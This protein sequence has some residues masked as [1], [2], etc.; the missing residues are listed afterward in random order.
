MG[1]PAAKLSVSVPSK[2]A[3]ELRR[4]VGARGLSGFVTRAIAHELERQRLGVLLAE[5]DAELGAVPPEE[6][7]RVRRQWPKR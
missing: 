7:A 1:H 2:L 3:E 6:L 5:M 4:T